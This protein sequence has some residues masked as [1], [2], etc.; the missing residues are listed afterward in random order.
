[1]GAIFMKS[2]SGI[3]LLFFIAASCF[4]RDDESWDLNSDPRLNF[5]FGISAFDGFFGFEYQNGHHS[6]GIGTP[7]HFSY[8]YYF[9]PYQDSKFW[10]V[11]F[12]S[13]SL[14]DEPDELDGVVYRDF[15]SQYFGF[16]GGKRWQWPSG[17]NMTAGVALEFYDD[18]YSNPGS[19]RKETRSGT[20]PFP[21]LSVGYKF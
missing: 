11:Y 1:M 8:R 15:A 6:F 21:A 4:A 16:G 14:E 19:D 17:W 7:T 5:S 20:F 13:Y 12:G 3:F 2:V 18:E 9:D 10:G